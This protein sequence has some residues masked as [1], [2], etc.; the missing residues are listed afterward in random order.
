MKRPCLDCGV[1]TDS[2]SRCA[3]HRAAA[4]RRRGSGAQRGYDAAWRRVSAF[5]LDRDGHVCRY[6]GGPATTAD[7]VV[8]LVNGGDRLEPANLVAACVACNSS[9][10]AR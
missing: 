4:G 5:V 7:H 10:G 2:G 6:C 9:K 3:A 1:L 8:A